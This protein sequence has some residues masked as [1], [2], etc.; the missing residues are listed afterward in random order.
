MMYLISQAVYLFDFFL[1]FKKEKV[2]LILIKTNKIRM[3]H[4]F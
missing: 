4:A 2:E 1:L 3:S